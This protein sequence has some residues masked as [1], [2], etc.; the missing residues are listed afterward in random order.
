MEAMTDPFETPRRRLAP[1][2]KQLLNTELLPER[3]NVRVYKDAFDLLLF[4][5]RTTVT[6]RREYRFTLAEEMKRTLQQLLTSIYEA[7]KTT[8]EECLGL[9]RSGDNICFGKD[10]NEP[11]VFGQNLHTIA[12]RVENVTV[13]KGRSSDFGVL[14]STIAARWGRDGMEDRNDIINSLMRS[15]SYY[16]NQQTLAWW[17]DHSGP[18]FDWYVS[19]LEGVVVTDGEAPPE[20]TVCWITPARYPELPESVLIELSIALA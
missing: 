5:Y 8:L 14:G 9:I 3:D 10:G 20:G 6:M 2:D 7:K 17:A 15:G 16:V 11:R 18:D 1:A 19:A 4:V 13:L 12:D